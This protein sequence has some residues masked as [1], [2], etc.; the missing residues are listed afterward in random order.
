MWPGG[1]G[2]KNPGE[3]LLP[4][5]FSFANTLHTQPFEVSSSDVVDAVE[6]G[7]QVGGCLGKR[8]NVFQVCIITVHGGTKA[9]A[10]QTGWQAWCRWKTEQRETTP[11]T[12]SDSLQPLGPMAPPPRVSEP[13]SSVSSWV[14]CCPD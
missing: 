12:P 8:R 11:P 4:P 9:H 5:R 2:K 10:Q 7:V 13:W 6:A 1:K 3:S 14:V